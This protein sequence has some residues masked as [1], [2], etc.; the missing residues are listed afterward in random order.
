ME[1]INDNTSLQRCCEILSQSNAIALDT[2]FVRE[3]T[4]YPALGL[5]QLSDG[6]DI[7]LVDPL[8]ISNWTPLQTLLTD[9][10]TVKV[11][12]SCGEDIEVIKVALN[13]KPVAFHDTQIAHAFI[14]DKPAIGLAALIEEYCGVK[15]DKGHARTNWLN[16]PLSP[17]QLEYAADDVRYLLDVYQKQVATMAQRQVTELVL[18][19]TNSL[20]EKRFETIQPQLAWRD[21]KSAWQLSP[22]ELAILKELIAW[23][24]KHAVQRNLAVNFVVHERSLIALAQRRPS[25]IKS[26]A[27]VPGIHHMEVKRHGKALL[28]CIE[29][30][31]AVPLED[32]PP[33]IKRVAEITGYKK[34][35]TDLK[36]AF[37]EVAKSKQLNPDILASKRMI[38]Q[39]ISYVW[40]VSS[41]SRDS[42]PELLTG[43]RGQL[44]SE[45]AENTVAKHQV[46]A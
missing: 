7:Y 8:E 13:V 12:H 41:W 18:A 36:H 25:N 21:V 4:Y 17:Q 5:V 38:N 34:I 35:Y 6:Q 3:R 40:Q 14:A 2:E 28:E 44:L 24:L 37:S 19:D 9:P 42:Q 46:E 10:D 11:I 26:M 15:L 29:R 43:W 32:C 27:N 33:K 30:G 31:K 16:R 45:V 39:Y 22:R 1:F 20:I 23:R